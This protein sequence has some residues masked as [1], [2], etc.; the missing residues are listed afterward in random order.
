[1]GYI[2]LCK[3][4]FAAI[5]GTDHTGSLEAKLENNLYILYLTPPT[6]SKS[7][8]GTLKFAVRHPNSGETPTAWLKEHY[9][10]VLYWLLDNG[11]TI[12]ERK[13]LVSNG[14]LA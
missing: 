2:D 14:R 11:C 6:L 9:D 10:S 7:I 3:I 12:G 1:M 5:Q 13:F 8:A 4:L